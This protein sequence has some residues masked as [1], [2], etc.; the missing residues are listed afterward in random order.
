MKKNI[1]SFLFLAFG[2]GAFHAAFA[3]E[4]EK[5]PRDGALGVFIDKEPNDTNGQLALLQMNLSRLQ[6]DTTVLLFMQQYGSRVHLERIYF[7][8]GTPDHEMIPGYL[9]TPVNLAKGTKRPGLVMVHGAL[10]ESLDWRFFRLI[11]EAV[12]RGYVVMFP[13]YH[14]STGYGET[15]YVNSYGV[16]DVADVLAAADY[17]AKQDF[18][19]AARLGIFGHSRGGLITLLTIERAPKRFQAAVEVS[20]LMDFLAYMSYKPDARRNEIAREAEFGGKLPSQNL[21]PYLD[22]TPLNFVEKIETPLL[23]LATTGDKIVPTKLNTARLI[24]L[25]KAHDKVYSGFVYDNAPGGH[26]FL[27][28]ESDEQRDCFKRTFEWFAKYLKPSGVP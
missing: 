9:F 5:G 28:G 19:D 18:V 27:F 14:G 2:L 26:N 25:L 21:P 13:E 10:H 6:V 4:A 22:A 3:A 12:A 24:E 11:D 20:G 17:F 1:R 23:A 8:A 7:P 15:I 16:T